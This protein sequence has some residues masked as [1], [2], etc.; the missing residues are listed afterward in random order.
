V[1]LFESPEDES[2]FIAACEAVNLR[3]LP[4][5]LASGAREIIHLSDQTL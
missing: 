5:E 4:L 1:A 2:A 3:V